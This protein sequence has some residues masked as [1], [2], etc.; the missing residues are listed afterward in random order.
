MTALLVNQLN[1]PAAHFPAPLDRMLIDYIEDE[2]DLS[3]P[4]ET[5]NPDGIKFKN[6]YFLCD[7]PYEIAVMPI[8]TIVDEEWNAG[9]TLQV[10]TDM[11]I[12]LRM[13][14]EDDVTGQLNTQLKDMEDKVM[15]IL[16]DY[17][18]YTLFG[19]REMRYAGT[20]YQLFHVQP[21]DQNAEADW[22]SVIT[23]R[24]FY[25]LDKVI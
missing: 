15:D 4:L 2:W 12:S 22:R 19:I 13:F 14:R 20:N 16:T 17:P 6:G 10:H 9:Y 8:Q 3:S 18:Q 7:T 1:A 21:T 5:G 23:G 24:L 11:A 25:Q